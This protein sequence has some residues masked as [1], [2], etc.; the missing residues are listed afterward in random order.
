MPM[1]FL[2]D[3]AELHALSNFSF[4]RGASHPE[5]LVLRAQA[6]GYKALA[7]TDECSL[8]GAV[9]AH[10]AARE[11]G[12]PLI[13]GT[14]ITVEKAKL[15]LLATDR[16]SYGAISALIT[17]GRRRSKKGTYSLTL[18]DVEALVPS[19]VL[20]LWGPRDDAGT[21]S[22]LAERFAGRAWLAA[23]L[24]CGPNDRAKLK[25]LRELGCQYGLPLV[26]AGDVHMHLRSRKRLH[27]VLSAV[28]LGKPVA[29]CGQAL[30]PNAERS[31]RLRM[32][33]AQLY[34]PE[35]LAQSVAIAERCRFSLHEL[36]Y[37]YPAELVP[38]EHTPK[39]WLAK[40]TEDG[41]RWRFPGG[42]PA[43]VREM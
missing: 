34:P 33:L 1:A 20:V 11:C 23:E 32:R 4:L 37:E 7:L 3:Y 36:R 16:R 17:T 26:A 27:D 2:P 43:K 40:L 12:L 9:R 18:A 8:A 30:H 29:Q 42:V 24:H 39:S 38:P 25:E 35:L 15:I 5:E 21:A 14:E 19:G 22:W 31:L 41:L 13:H 28:R 10:F 6:L